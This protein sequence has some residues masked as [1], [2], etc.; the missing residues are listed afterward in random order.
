MSVKIEKVPGWQRNV[1]KNVSR[2]LDAHIMSDGSQSSIDV[3]IQNDFFAALN[4]SEFKISAIGG[5]SL[6]PDE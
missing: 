4:L 5:R 1:E 3:A 2:A 6:E